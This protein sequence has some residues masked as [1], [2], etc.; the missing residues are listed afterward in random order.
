MKNFRVTERVKVQLRGESYNAFNQRDLAAP[1]MAPT[2]TAFG[3]I[4]GTLADS[5]ARWGMVALKVMF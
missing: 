5:N 2:N 1:N 4:T 3:Q